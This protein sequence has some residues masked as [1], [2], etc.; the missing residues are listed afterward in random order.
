M[1]FAPAYPRIS[2]CIPTYRRPDLLEAALQSVLEQDVAPAE[3]VVGDDSPDEASTAVV[4]RVRATTAVPIRYQRNVPSLGQSRNVD[5]LF[6]E[7]TGAYLILLH[8][9][10]LLLPGAIAALAQPVRD[11]ARV[12]A[13]FGKQNLIDAAGTF[14]P[15]ATRELN[16][17]YGRH[18]RASGAVPG[19]LEACLLQ[20]F[21]ND[22][23]LIA[24][25]LAQTI[26][27]PDDPEIG[28][29]ADLHFGIRVGQALAP[30][31]LWYVDAFVGSYRQSPDGVSRI[32]ATRKTD[33]PV[34]GVGLYRTLERLDLP[35]ASEYARAYLMRSF[36][37]SMVKGFALRRD[38]RTALR[39]YA[40]P[41][42]GWK[43]RLSPKGAYHLAL[44]A[45][46]A[47][48]RL[49]RYD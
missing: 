26:G 36:M 21:P 41:S 46:P 45:A 43:K 13:V 47:V 10:D 1:T 8:D 32:A 9:D 20:Q 35:P 7:A 19:P 34:A 42:Y 30:G 49:R 40:S 16:I 15:D 3:I 5:R 48:D 17:R 4:D 33:H 44:I 11:D 37:D 14:L 29:R 24:T 25:E 22:A 28:V 31:E 2:V 18:E 27:Y 6:R 39:L 12:K 23:Y 38:R